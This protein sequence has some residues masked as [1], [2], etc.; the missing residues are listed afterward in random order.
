MT[1]KKVLPDMSKMLPSY[2]TAAL[3]DYAQCLSI[4]L[5][6]EVLSLLNNRVRTHAAS[7]V[8]EPPELSYIILEDLNSTMH[9]ENTVNSQMPLSQVVVVGDHDDDNGDDC[10]DDDDGED[11]Y[12]EAIDCENVTQRN[13]TTN[14]LDE[15]ITH[16]KQTINSETSNKAHGVQPAKNETGTDGQSKGKSH[17]CCDSCTIKPK[18]KK[19]HSM[20]QCNACM[21]WFHEQ[22]V[23]LDKSSEPIYI[24]LCPTCR[25]FPKTV[26][27]ELFVLKNELN[28]L[29]QSTNSILTVVK[30]LTSNI[31]RSIGNIN[32]RITALNNQISTNDKSLAGTLQTLSTTTNNIKTT[33]DQESCQILN[34]TSAVLDKV[35]TT[36]TEFSQQSTVTEKSSNKQ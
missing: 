24:W 28:G 10:D 33:F 30:E 7:E 34:K 6:N 11:D 15:S 2:E 31:E 21:S 9:A 13:D 26:T 4:A 14:Q 8:T 18:S 12:G 22:C 16:Q 3:D 29:K 19:K 20:I 1:K 36:K 35:K 23:G 5:Q 27:T 17:K 25:E 32:D